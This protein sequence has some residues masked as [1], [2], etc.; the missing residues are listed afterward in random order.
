MFHMFK[1]VKYVSLKKD[2]IIFFKKKYVLK[3]VAYILKLNLLSHKRCVLTI[4][5]PYIYKF[6]VGK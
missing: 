1:K 6:L 5:F 3:N 2:I 4:N